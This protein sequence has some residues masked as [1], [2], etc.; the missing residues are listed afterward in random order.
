MFFCKT[1]IMF[2]TGSFIISELRLCS[3]CLHSKIKATL[4]W[5]H[6][7]VSTFQAFSP[8]VHYVSSKWHRM[9]MVN[10]IENQV[11][12]SITSL[13]PFCISYLWSR[14]WTWHWHM[15][16]SKNNWLNVITCVNVRHGYQQMS[17]TK[18]AFHQKC[19]CYRIS[20]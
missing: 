6:H 3:A 17:N 20:Y 14:L 18:Y 16:T 5:R 9:N 4:S 19:Q 2:C 11:F 8:L 15:G 13:F 10:L 7:T 1:C 12:Y